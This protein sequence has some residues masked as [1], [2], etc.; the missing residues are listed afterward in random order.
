M[1]IFSGSLQLRWH[2]SK[3]QCPIF[4]GKSEPQP[5]SLSDPCIVNL[6]NVK[7]WVSCRGVTC[8]HLCGSTWRRGSAAPPAFWAGINFFRQGTVLVGS[9][10]LRA[11]LNTTSLGLSLVIR[12]IGPKYCSYP[13]LLIMSQSAALMSVNAK[14]LSMN[15]TAICESFFFIVMGNILWN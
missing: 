10:P 2:F 6:Y 14:S 13:W 15:S 12:S 3:L 9:I 8:L 1:F 11:K 4:Q 5:T 7:T